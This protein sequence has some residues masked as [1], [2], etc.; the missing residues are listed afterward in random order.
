MRR[1]A[2]VLGVAAALAAAAIAVTAGASAAGQNKLTV[3][4]YG[5][6]PYL[7][8]AFPALPHAE[9]DATPGFIDTINADPD[10]QEVIHVGDIHSGSEPCT[11]AYDQSIFDKWTAF[12]RPLIYTPGDNEW[13]D[14]TKANEEPGSDNDNVATHPD[15]P[16]ENLALIRQIFF[17]NPGWTLG[18]HPMQVISQGVAFDHGYPKDAEYVE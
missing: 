17:A 10:L 2:I 8:K 7:D 16:L 14:C 15:L 5:D 13:S 1:W 3:A 4:V 6:S 18:L 12:Q 9:F 11:H